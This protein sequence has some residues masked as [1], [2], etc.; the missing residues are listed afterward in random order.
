MAGALQLIER[1]VI[2]RLFS[3]VVPLSGIQKMG[4][5]FSALSIAFLVAGLVFLL[6][7]AHTWLSLHYGQ[8]IAAI[9]TGIMSLALSV[10][11]AGILFAIIHQQ[12]I[13]AKKLRKEVTDKIQSSLSTLE[14]ELSDPV[15]EHPKT[16]LIIA[17]CLGFLAEDQLFD[18]NNSNQKGNS[19]E[20]Q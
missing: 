2:D 12:K 8:G 1:V 20:N 11:I 17:S 15:R 18:L 7:G 3:A 16:A 10:I 13:R 6:Y 5:F 14:H 4:Q 19:H 9:A